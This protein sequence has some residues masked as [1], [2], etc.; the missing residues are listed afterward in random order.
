[1]MRVGALRAVPSQ[2][3]ATTEVTLEPKMATDDDD[4]DDDDDSDDDDD[5]YDVEDD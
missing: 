1:M 5:E 2:A 3:S 4:D